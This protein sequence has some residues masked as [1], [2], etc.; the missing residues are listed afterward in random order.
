MKG[1]NDHFSEMELNNTFQPVLNF[2]K[3]GNKHG[4]ISLQN[5]LIDNDGNI[6]LK[7]PK[8]TKQIKPHL[9]DF[10]RLGYIMLQCALLKNEDEIEAL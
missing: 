6:R 5:I 8:V 4:A 3:S 7:D 9:N 1:K 10:Q 2:L